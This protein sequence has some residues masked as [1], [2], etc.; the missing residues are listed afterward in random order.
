M[1]GSA[2]VP[3]L[4]GARL[5]HWGLLTLGQLLLFSVQFLFFQLYPIP[6]PLTFPEKT[7]GS[8]HKTAAASPTTMR[9]TGTTALHAIDGK[10]LGT[11]PKR[12]FGEARIPG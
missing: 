9:I 2:R 10:F 8:C 12:E 1:L 7:G 11:W 4:E 6:V 5:S 3:W